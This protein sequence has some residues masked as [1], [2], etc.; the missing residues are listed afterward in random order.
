MVTKKWV[1][2]TVVIVL[3][4]IAGFG[5]SS[6]LHYDS[7]K[8]SPK[9]TGEDLPDYLQGICAKPDDFDFV[10]G[11]LRNEEDIC[12]LSEAYYLQPDFYRKSW[13]DGKHQYGEQQHD[14]SRW[15]VYGHGAYPA[16]PKVTFN[17]NEIYK[18]THICTLY[19]TG[20]GVETW[21]GIKLVPEKSKYFEVVIDPDEFLLPPSF[22]YFDEGWVK[23]LNITVRAK[24]ILLV[25]HYE[26]VVDVVSPSE[27]KSNEWESEV[28]NQNISI[29]RMLEECIMQ[30]KEKG[31]NLKC[32]ELIRDRR[33]KYVESGNIEVGGRL[34]IKII[35]DG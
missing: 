2:G 21:Q 4:C 9:E 35:V 13:E 30:N 20:W 3:I 19:R 32:E 16:H 11:E 31:L 14:Y 29:K 27:E 6:L 10:I 26:I 23:K 18:E 34:I 5:I 17:T 12:G 22:P 15:L 24:Q 28:L 8:S 25:G 1:F 33:N 7:L